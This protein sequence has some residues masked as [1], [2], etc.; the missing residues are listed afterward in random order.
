[1]C[2]KDVIPIWAALSLYGCPLT[3]FTDP[4]FLFSESMKEAGG[5]LQ[6][7]RHDPLTQGISSSLEALMLQVLLAHDR[8]HVHSP[9]V[10][11]RHM[12]RCPPQ[13]HAGRLHSPTQALATHQSLF[14]FWGV[15]SKCQ[16]PKRHSKRNLSDSTKS[17]KMISYKT[18]W[19]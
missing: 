7:A 13:R 3:H 6:T 18:H 10:G 2:D 16:V 19:G 14:L 8:T 15:G 4:S 12:T 11:V 9:A 5:R 1:M 17:N